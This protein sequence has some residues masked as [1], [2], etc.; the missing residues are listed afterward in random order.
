MDTWRGGEGLE[1]TGSRG[2]RSVKRLLTERGIPPQE[3]KT[4]PCIR[5]DG[6]LAAV[7]GVGTDRHYLPKDGGR[8]IKINFYKENM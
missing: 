3:R 6:E 8:A 5:L 1:L 7:H 2:K 4:V